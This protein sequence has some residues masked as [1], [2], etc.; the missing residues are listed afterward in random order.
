MQAVYLS[1]GRLSLAERPAPSPAGEIP[2]DVTLA[3]I[4]RTDLELVRGYMDFTGVPGH[5]FVG[6]ARAGRLAGRRVVGEINCPCRSC[7][8]CA[9][10]RHHHCP[11]RT[12][13][14]IAGRDGAFAETL[15]LPEANLIP[16]PDEL[17]DRAA[18]FAEPLAAA[19]R[20][21]EQVAPAP[22][23][24]AVV[25]GDGKLGLLCALVLA[26]RP[27]PAVTLVG[28]HPEKMERISAPGLVRVVA[29][30]G[31]GADVEE[32]A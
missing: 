14:G 21:T 7:P 8:E 19:L 23:A 16:L 15:L 13:L 2:V 29:G 10:G 26:R 11:H 25:L 27:G 9:A 32:S 20:I 28:R 22:A 31:A 18:V 30:A 6:I 24:K 4:C 1:G 17:P 3:G 12:V 5:E